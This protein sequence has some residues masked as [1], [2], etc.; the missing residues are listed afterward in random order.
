MAEALVDLDPARLDRVRGAK[1][2]ADVVR[3]DV[4]S[5][6]IVTVIRHTDGIPLVGPGDGDE[7]RTEDLLARKAPATFAKMVG[8]V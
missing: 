2:A 1:C 6:P 3:P 4:G 5:K 7:H 8:I